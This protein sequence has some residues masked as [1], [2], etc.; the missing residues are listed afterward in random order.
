MQIRRARPPRA[1][2]AAEAVEPQ[3]VAPE[4]AGAELDRVDRLELELQQRLADPQTLRRGDPHDL[5]VAR[6]EF[7]AARRKI[8]QALHVEMRGAELSLPRHQLQP[9]AGAV[10][11][12]VDDQDEIAVRRGGDHLEQPDEA[13]I[14]GRDHIDLRRCQR[15]RRQEVEL[16]EPRP[17]QAVQDGPEPDRDDMRRRRHDPPPPPLL[18]PRLL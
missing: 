11:G 4:I 9:Q 17:D 5:L 10:I 13:G 6:A 2:E 16:P 18:C 12:A 14:G 15:D 3:R 7:R 1:E 8:E